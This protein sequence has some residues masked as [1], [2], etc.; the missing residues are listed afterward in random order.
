MSQSWLCL[1]RLQSFSG[2]VTH[3]P[4][5]EPLDMYKSDPVSDWLMVLVLVTE[6]NVMS[7]RLWQRQLGSVAT[8]V[9]KV[10]NNLLPRQ[11]HCRREM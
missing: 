8:A 11:H 2:S 5:E 6:H 4:C 9:D 7:R 3:W 10:D 1:A